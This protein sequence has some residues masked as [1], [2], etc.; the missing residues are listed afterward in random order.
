M[1]RPLRDA[2]GWREKPRE[3]EWYGLVLEISVFIFA[4]K[5][6]WS[7]A[8]PESHDYD[9]DI[10]RHKIPNYFFIALDILAGRALKL[11]SVCCCVL[12]KG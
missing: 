8:F 12:T 7:R 1:Y 11:P 3:V 2:R 4:R 5:V 10:F 9:R 6:S